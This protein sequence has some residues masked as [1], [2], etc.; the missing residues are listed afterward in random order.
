M[1]ELQFIMKNK[2]FGVCEVVARYFG[3]T[4]YVILLEVSGVVALKFDFNGFDTSSLIDPY[5]FPELYAQAFKIASDSLKLNFPEAKISKL[6]S[7]RGVQ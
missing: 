2:S 1:N 6:E 5:I 3:M 4:N 7:N